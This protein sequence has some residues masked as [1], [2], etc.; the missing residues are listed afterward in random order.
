MKLLL[1][2][3]WRWPIYEEAF[4]RALSEL[5]HTVVPLSFSGF[6]HGKIGRY[7]A[8]LPFPSPALWLINRH[9]LQA[10]MRE[11]PDLVLVWRGS[12]VLPWVIRR[13]NRLGTLTVSY[14]NDDPF[15]PRVPGK[16][17]WHHPILWFW[18]RASVKEY[19]CTFFYR[20]INVHEAL[21]MGARHAHVLK[22]YFVPWKDRP[23]ALAEED[24]KTF[25]CDVVF[26]GHYEA[27][28][29]V[30]HLRALVNAGLAVRLFGDG[31]WSRKVL[32]GLFDYF[33]TIVPAEGEDY[34]RA[35]C[36]ARVCLAF[37]SKMNRDTYTRRCF[38]IPAHARVMLAE[39]T[40]DLLHM[41]AEDTEA[42]YFSSSRELVEKT[43]WLVRN[44]EIADT[45]G[46]AG[47]RRVWEDG[48]DVRNRAAE[49]LRL[50]PLET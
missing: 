35:L 29:R 48:H 19:Q 1:A 40:D 9:L 12:H 14:N 49:F 43:T 32:G 37:L 34:S 4:G 28:D 45:I 10:T 27:D 7:Q 3:D 16:V 47:H 25:E 33:G 21:A 38:E 20:Q 39:R 2:G 42:C 30:A 5:G 13:L 15:G 36:S 22:P 18:Y 26:V 8:A 44:P 11:R 17:P 31:T 50:L 23:V 6:F 41:F 46:R 24:K